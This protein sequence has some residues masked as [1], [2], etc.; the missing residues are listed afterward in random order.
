MVGHTG[1]YEATK[2]AVKALD[3]CLKRL[4]KKAQE[5]NYTLL[6]IADHGNCDYMIDNNNNIV[7]SHSVSP[8]PCIVTDKNI[9]LKNGRLCDVAPTLLNIMGIEIPSE[10]TGESLI[11]RN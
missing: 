8:V 4:Y 3:K 9:K 11:E 1:N 10:M 6:I 2:K 7:T 5:K